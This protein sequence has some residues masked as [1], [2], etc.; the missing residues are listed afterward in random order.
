MTPTPSGAE[1]LIG[2]WQGRVPIM[3][4]VTCHRNIDAQSEALNRAIRDQCRG[5]KRRHPSSSFVILSGLAEG[6]DRLVARIAMEE[7]DAALIAVLPMP[8][9]EFEK[10]FEGD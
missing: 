6:A 3:L 4:G 8:R 9:A 5:L 2:R 1:P 10:D 7:L